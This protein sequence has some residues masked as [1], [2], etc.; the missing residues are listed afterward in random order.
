MDKNQLLKQVKTAVLEIEP[1]ATVILYGSRSRGDASAESDWDFLVLVDG[2]LNDNR[3]AGIRDQ[4]YEIEWECCEVLS[5]IIR[6]NEQWNSPLYKAM[7][8]HANVEQEG[9]VL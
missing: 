7:P 9:I 3:I 1:L 5:A 4:V 2:Q 8:F 6:S